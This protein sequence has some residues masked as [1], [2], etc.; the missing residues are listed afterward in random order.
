MMFREMITV[1]SAIHTE[2]INTLVVKM[3]NFL[4]L[5]KMVHIVTMVL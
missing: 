1:Y 5:M 2:H 4:I 3:Q